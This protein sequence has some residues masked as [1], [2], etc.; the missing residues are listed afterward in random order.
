MRVLDARR[1]RPGSLAKFAASRLASLR[2]NSLA[3]E[4]RN[5]QIDS[6]S[7]STARRD[8][9]LDGLAT[10][11]ARSEEGMMAKAAA[12]NERGLIDD[13]QGHGEIAVS[14]PD[15]VRRYFRT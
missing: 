7:L 12:L 4:Q 14:L 8:E 10:V 13:Y 2:V 3:A 5:F 11:P 1:T 15:D 9:V 6:L